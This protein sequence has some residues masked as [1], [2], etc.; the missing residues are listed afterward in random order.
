MGISHLMLYF[1]LSS[2]LELL[3]L[4]AEEE[5]SSGSPG[6]TQIFSILVDINKTN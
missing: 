2:E 6:K 5:E 3:P 4:R 1:L